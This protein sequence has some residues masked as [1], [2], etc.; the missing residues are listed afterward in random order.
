[1]LLG[2]LAVSII[3]YTMI[4]RISTQKQ[5]K[6]YCPHSIFDLLSSWLLLFD[7]MLSSGTKVHDYMVFAL[8]VHQTC[9]HHFTLNVGVARKPLKA[10]QLQLFF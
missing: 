8:F 7:Q 1:M 2:S 9:V 5:T 6:C 3:V 10:L 4:G